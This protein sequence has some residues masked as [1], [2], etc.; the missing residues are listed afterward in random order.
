MVAAR[1]TLYRLPTTHSHCFLNSRDQ[2]ADTFRIGS[3]D[4]LSDDQAR[5]DLRDD[6]L[7]LELVYAYGLASFDQVDDVRGQ[8]EH[9]RQLDRA[10]ERHELRPDPS[11]VEILAG[12]APVL[13]RHFRP[14]R[15][16]PPPRAPR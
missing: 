15:P 3:V 9:G 13:R 1:P 6:V 10:A 7:Q 11:A 5:R 16:R 12:H 4:V 2:L 8:V 14:H